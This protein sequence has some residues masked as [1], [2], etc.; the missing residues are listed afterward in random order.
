[1]TLATPKSE[2]VDA[3]GQP[4]GWAPPA[5][6][7]RDVG[8]DGRTQLVVSAP[9]RA[10]LDTHLQLVGQL[11]A[12]LGLL[13]R[14]V[15]D[16]RNPGPNGAP[17]VDRVVL[18]LTHGRVRDVLVRYTDLL[19]HDARCEVFVRGALGEVVGL[20]RDGLIYCQPADPVFEDTL[21]ADGFVADVPTTIL[22]RDYVKHWFHAENDG[23]EDALV[24]EL[25]MVEVPWRG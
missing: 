6:F 3:K 15:V 18:E 22:D 9:T 5:G 17:P 7:V 2:S 14:Q 24:A 19:H 10:L 16:R 11:Q 1:V 8:R 12:P 13:Y 25:A 23:L 4:D 21:L 20:D